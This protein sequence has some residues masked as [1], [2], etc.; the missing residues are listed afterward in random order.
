MHP[1]CLD[2]SFSHYGFERLYGNDNP[3]VM[4]I[5]V[6]SLIFSCSFVSSLVCIAKCLM[7][8]PCQ[9]KASTN[10][11]W[12]A[13]V[14]A[15]GYLSLHLQ[16]GLQQKIQRMKESKRHSSSWK[17]KNGQ[18]RQ[19]SWRHPMHVDRTHL[20]TRRHRCTLDEQVPVKHLLHLIFSLWIKYIICIIMQPVPN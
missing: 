7:D 19:E 16:Y 3:K 2:K 11:I 20:P 1:G 6:S 15:I 4:F 8:G 9:C 18:R 13:T 12:D 10:S 17:I 14:L 5:M